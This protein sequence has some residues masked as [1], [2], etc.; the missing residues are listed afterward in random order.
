MQPTGAECVCAN[1]KKSSV[2]QKRMSTN[3]FFKET[4]DSVD[5]VMK[6]FTKKMSFAWTLPSVDHFVIVYYSRTRTTIFSIEGRFLFASLCAKSF[7]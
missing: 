4:E 7:E 6:I 3:R 5:E 1:K 2:N